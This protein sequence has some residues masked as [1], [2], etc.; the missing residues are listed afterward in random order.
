MF[1]RKFTWIQSSSISYEE[2]F[3]KEAA[4]KSLVQSNL[5]VDSEL[6]YFLD[7]SIFIATIDLSQKDFS[8]PSLLKRIPKL[9]NSLSYTL[10]N[11]PKIDAI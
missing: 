3:D 10:W 2:V 1:Q 5:I 9:F 4:L 6:K 8:V 7:F 11:C